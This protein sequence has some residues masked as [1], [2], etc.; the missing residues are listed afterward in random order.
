[1]VT[2]I[3]E[4]QIIHYDPRNIVDFDVA[5]LLIRVYVQATDNEIHKLWFLML[6]EL[7]EI[8]SIDAGEYLA[9]RFEPNGLLAFH[10]F[11]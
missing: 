5:K 1:M 9:Y 10:T 7:K 2:G 3:V 6:N 11:R 4:Y 8:L